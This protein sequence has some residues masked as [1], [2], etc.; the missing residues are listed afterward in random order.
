[1]LPCGE[2]T[3]GD[4][5]SVLLPNR[6]HCRRLMDIEAVVLRAAFHESRSS[7]GSN[8]QRRLGGTPGRGRALNIR[9]E[10]LARCPTLLGS[11]V[12]GEPGWDNCLPKFTVNPMR[13]A[14]WPSMRSNVAVLLLGCRCTAGAKK[15]LEPGV[16]RLDSP[17][18]WVSRSIPGVAGCRSASGLQSRANDPWGSGPNS[19]ASECW[20][21]PSRS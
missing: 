1:M 3:A 21:T 17:A 19:E 8:G 5:P 14:S 7:L 9:S 6:G 15:R 20:V 4:H 11:E 12:A 2:D 16:L 13:Q 10:A 18:C